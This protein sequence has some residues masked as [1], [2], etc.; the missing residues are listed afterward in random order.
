M[1]REV[2]LFLVFLLCLT[3][4]KSQ[5]KI[6]SYHYIGY[7][8]GHITVREDDTWDV[9]LIIESDSHV[10]DKKYK[11]LKKGDKKIINK[12]SENNFN[13]KP[14]YIKDD[15]LILQKITRITKNPITVDY[16]LVIESDKYNLTIPIESLKNTFV[17]NEEKNLV[18]TTGKPGHD[19]EGCEDAEHITQ[20]IAQIDLTKKNPELENIGIRGKYLQ[21]INEHLY[22][23][24]YFEAFDYDKKYNLYRV[25]LR[26]WN[27]TELVFR[28][29]YYDCYVFPNEKY[30]FASIFNPDRNNVDFIL[31]DMNS[32]SYEFLKDIDSIYVPPYPYEKWKYSSSAGASMYSYKHETP[33]LALGQYRYIKDIPKTYTKKYRVLRAFYKKDGRTIYRGYEAFEDLPKKVNLDVPLKELRDHNFPRSPKPFF[34]T[35]ITDELMYNATKEELSKLSSK[36]LRLLRNAF[37][38]RLGYGF[39]SEDLQ[40][41]FMQ[42]NWYENSLDRKKLTNNEIIVPPQDKKRVELIMGVEQGK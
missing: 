42:F 39:E 7:Y 6:G 26:K 10:G 3:T 4:L 5:V 27:E 33:F 41:F 36:K 34:G 16:N 1:K 13:V 19:C 15:L 12:T 35:F 37:F 14:V 40:E 30:L 2:L 29:T 23:H 38:A 22:F 8:E 21:I 20:N 18:L 28:Q 32:K 11:L 24:Q 25:P 9:Y 17:A 31:Y